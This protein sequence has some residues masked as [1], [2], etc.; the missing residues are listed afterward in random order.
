[1]AVI[2]PFR[3]IFYNQAKI[4]DISRVVSPPYDVISPT[5][6]NLLCQSHPCNI[7]RIDFGKILPGDDAKDNRYI[8]AREFFQRWLREKI[9]IQD[10]SPAFYLAAQNFRYK[11]RNFLRM[12]VI[13][14]LRLRDDGAVLFHEKTS[15]RP[16]RDRLKLLSAVK[17][18]INPVF[19]LFE[20]DSRLLPY[21]RGLYA[22]RKPFVDFEFEGVRNRLW[23]IDNSGVI[24]KI[25]KIFLSK[26]IF[27]ADGHHRY[28]VSLSYRSSC[29]R[30]NP[31]HS[32]KEPYNYV[33]V[34]LSPLEDRAL[35]IL[36]THR[37]LKK[38]PR[39]LR[40]R[41]ERYFDIVACSK[42]VLLSLL[43]RTGKKGRIF[44]MY[45]G[46][47]RFFTLRL[48][49]DLAP[50]ELIRKN[51]P[52]SWKRLDVSI[53]H[54]LVIERIFKIKNSHFR[55]IHHTQDVEQ[56]IR[57]VDRGGFK[58]AFFLN[59]TSAAQV[60][61]VSLDGERMPHKS[62]YFYPKLLSGLVMNP[63]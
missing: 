19:T 40:T 10:A 4:K 15:P 61:E 5:R 22:K 7:V 58:I 23:R 34:Y 47:Q 62:T 46:R 60:K 39:D 30:K 2:A 48:K 27:L 35:K 36:S 55:F 29:R 1:M 50:E 41:L 53:L 9:L 25:K 45:L 21:L 28:E 24:L 13:C 57:E 26:K 37:L 12:G 20:D 11:G 14:R 17:A 16:K 51:K 33:M 8:R 31:R 54:A 6:Q 42:D 59:P 52:I 56:A 44:G 3:G 32:G 18:N 43:D 49:K 63:V 38:L